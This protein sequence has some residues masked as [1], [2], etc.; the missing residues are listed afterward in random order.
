MFPLLPSI[1]KF[2]WHHRI[3]CGFERKGSYR[4]WY[5]KNQKLTGDLLMD[6]EKFQDSLRAL[7]VDDEAGVR[8]LLISAL[9]KEGFKCDSAENG[10]DART[11]VAERP[12]DLVVTDLAMPRGHGH[13]L[14]VELMAKKNRPT[15][16]VVTGV[17][18]PRMAKDLMVRGVDDIFYKPVEFLP[19]AAKLRLLVE[20]R[21]KPETTVRSDRPSRTWLSKG[22]SGHPLMRVTAEEVAIKLR[23]FSGIPPVSRT[24]VEVFHLTSN[25]DSDIRQVAAAVQREPA[26]VTDVLRFANS[27]SFN[28]SGKKVTDVE[29]AVIRLGCKRVGELALTTATAAAAAQQSIPFM[30][31]GAIWRKCLS[32]GICMEIF[33]EQGHHR[34]QSEELFVAAV[35]QPMGRVVLAAMF[36]QLYDRMLKQC[37]FENK[38][39]S[40]FE[41]HAFPDTPGAIVSDALGLWGIPEEIH[42]PLRYATL[43]FHALGHLPDALRRQ[44]EFIKLAVFIGEIAT[45][46]F[47]SWDLVDIPPA[48]VLSRLGISALDTLLEH[49][50]NDLDAIV[51][52]NADQP[53]KPRGALSTAVP[54]PSYCVAYK[55]LCAGPV[56]LIPQITACDG[57]HLMPIADETAPVETRVTNCLGTPVQELV[58]QLHS[59]TGQALLLATREQADRLRRFGQVLVMPCS[60]G[61]LR[62]ALVPQLPT[63]PSQ[64]RRTEGNAKSLLATFS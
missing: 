62:N 20:R 9:T 32:A 16:A 10:E 48:S 23:S 57:I 50:R 25:L 4:P 29:D 35:L 63:L 37:L 3:A 26:L 6:N 53:G 55:S 64:P 46:Q 44:V 24:A 52:W 61:L 19:L 14:I 31:L 43:P 45:G 49:C 34:D 60:Y 1:T 2:S 39:L 30:P 28:P 42:R 21:T 56:D 8:R 15:V 17:L 18:E 59:T 47:E 11:L 51:S 36:P 13:A 38:P 41:Q 58:K 40:E 7:V 22:V 54:L 12:Y 33:A 27:A 5:G